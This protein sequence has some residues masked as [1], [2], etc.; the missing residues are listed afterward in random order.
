MV[1]VAPPQTPK[2]ESAGA[3]AQA[4]SPSSGTEA[5]PATAAAPAS[6]S[7]SAAPA[8]D[9][10]KAKKE[11]D[12]KATREDSKLPK[13][14]VADAKKEEGKKS[15]K[16]DSKEAELRRQAEENVDEAL[17][18]AELEATKH[19]EENKEAWKDLYS[20]FPQSVYTS[21]DRIKNFAREYVPPFSPFLPPLPCHFS[22]FSYLNHPYL[23]ELLT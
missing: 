12:R 2:Q 19:R 21:Y 15:K 14:A 10:D 18:I 11:A 13:G 9:A 17:E 22:F 4:P 5:K 3:A 20:I 6:P 8:A 7:A 1:K 16:K 23:P